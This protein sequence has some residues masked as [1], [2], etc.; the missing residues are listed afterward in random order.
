MVCETSR[1]AVDI[2]DRAAPNVAQS[3]AVAVAHSKFRCTDAQYMAFLS[4]V[5]VLKQ[6]LP[7]WSVKLAAEIDPERRFSTVN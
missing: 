5:P 1:T 4:N 2:S 7:W 3:M 6:V